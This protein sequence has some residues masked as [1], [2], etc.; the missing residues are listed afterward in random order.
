MKL[1]KN[2]KGNAVYLVDADQGWKWNIIRVRVNK[3]KQEKLYFPNI[4]TIGESSPRQKQKSRNPSCVCHVPQ[5]S[6]ERKH[7]LM[8]IE[9]QARLKRRRWRS[10]AYCQAS[11]ESRRQ[12]LHQNIRPVVDTDSNGRNSTRFISDQPYS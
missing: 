10:T 11:L 6:T 12:D 1:K 8:S 2:A 4:Y 3:K 7:K 9:E 5:I